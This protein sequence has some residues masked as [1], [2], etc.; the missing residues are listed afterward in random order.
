MTGSALHEA[1]T[2]LAARFEAAAIPDLSVSDGPN[3]EPDALCLEVA[4]A[5]EDRDAVEIDRSREAAGGFGGM[6]VI[7]VW[8]L[9]SNWDGNLAVAEARAGLS[10]TFRLLTAAL[11]ADVHLGGAVEMARVSQIS[12]SPQQSEGGSMATIA[13]AVQITAFP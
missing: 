1:V 13:F 4:W 2:A 12:Y 3:W 10:A 7:V 11:E 5:G 6:E 8:C 9:L